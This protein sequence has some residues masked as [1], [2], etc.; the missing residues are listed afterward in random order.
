MT[1]TEINFMDWKSKKQIFVL[2]RTSEIQ[3]QKNVKKI[4]F[5]WNIIPVPFPKYS[6]VSCSTGLSRYLK[7]IKRLEHLCRL[8]RAF[9][10]GCETKQKQNSIS[11]VTPNAVDDPSS[12]LD[13]RVGVD[14]MREEFEEARSWCRARIMDTKLVQ[15]SLLHVDGTSI[16]DNIGLSRMYTHASEATIIG[17]DMCTENIWWNTRGESFYTLLRSHCPFFFLYIFQFSVLLFSS[18]SLTPS[19]S[20]FFLSVSFDNPTFAVYSYWCVVRIDITRTHEWNK[21]RIFQE[22]RNSERARE[23]ERERERFIECSR[24]SQETAINKLNCRDA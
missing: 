17:H 7:S 14:S 6:S 1:F 22:E 8:F 10:D 16:T 15:N 2:P 12:I 20:T 4:I 23:R 13:C 18:P 24:Q 9:F 19:L 5:L 3:Y 21:T 11:V